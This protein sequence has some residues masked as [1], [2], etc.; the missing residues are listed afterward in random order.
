MSATP[1]AL[2]RIIA[3]LADVERRLTLLEESAAKRSDP[4]ESIRFKRMKDEVLAEIRGGNL[5]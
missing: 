5:K 1:D 2:D 3:R 4:F